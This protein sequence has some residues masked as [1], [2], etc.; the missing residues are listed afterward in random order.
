MQ[1]RFGPVF[2]WSFDFKNR[3]TKTAVQS[4]AVLVQSSPGLFA[5]LK[6]GPSNTNKTMSMGMVLLRYNHPIP[7]PIPVSH[8]NYSSMNEHCV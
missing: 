8:L 1:D 2:L 5:S 7:V 3:K 4:F 6:T